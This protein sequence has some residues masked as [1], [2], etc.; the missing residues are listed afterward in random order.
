MGSVYV[1]VCSVKKPSLRL[2][3]HN[4]LDLLLKPQV[5]LS[6]LTERMQE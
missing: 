3:A 1:S 5:M 4:V 6:R 2:F